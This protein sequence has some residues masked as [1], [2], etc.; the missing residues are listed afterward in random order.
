MV[1][2]LADEADAGEALRRSAIAPPQP[3]I[4]ASEAVVI[5]AGLRRPGTHP[6]LG[7]P[8]LDDARAGRMVG[9]LPIEAVAS[10]VHQPPATTQVSLERVEHLHRIIF[11]MRSG[12]H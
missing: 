3:T 5:L 8:H 12:D 2:A 11:W 6:T 7:A 10:E 4:F 9:D 1:E